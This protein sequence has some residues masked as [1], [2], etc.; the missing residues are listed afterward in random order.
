[1]ALNLGQLI[2]GGAAFARGQRETEQAERIARQ[3]QLQIEEQNRLNRLR[4]IQTQQAGQMGLPQAPSRFMDF[5]SIGGAPPGPLALAAPAAA[6]AVAPP[7]AAAPPAAPAAA[8]AA[9]PVV[10]KTPSERAYDRLKTDPAAIQAAGQGLTKDE[11]LQVY[12]VSLRRGDIDLASRLAPF[13]ITKHGVGQQELA[14]LQGQMSSIRR[15]TGEDRNIPAEIATGL[16]EIA[17]GLGFGETA[18]EARRARE[19]QRLAELRGAPAAPPAAAPPAAP[20]AAAPTTGARGIRNNNPGNIRPSDDKWQG[21]TGVDKAGGGKGYITFDT[22]ENGI[23]AMTKNLMTYQ[24]RGL[25]TVEKIINTWAPAADKND[26]EAYIRN[27]TNRLG[28]ARDSKLNL[29]NP[30]VMKALVTSIIQHENGAMPYTDQVLN[31]GIGAG[32]GTEPTMV[33]A[34]APPAAAPAAPEIKPALVSTAGVSTQPERTAERV[35]SY[36]AANPQ[37][38][39]PDRENL[40]QL[41][42]RQRERLANQYN[43]YVQSGMGPQAMELLGEVDKLDQ[44]YRAERLMLDGTEALAQLEYGNDPRAISAVLS[45][46]RGQPVNFEAVQDGRFRMTMRDQEGKMQE[47]GIYSREEVG[48]MVREYYD[49][50]YREARQAFISKVSEKRIESQLKTQE[51]LSEIQAQMIKDTAVEMVK[52]NIKQRELGTEVVATNLGDGKV[53]ISNKAGT[54]AFMIDTA[55]GQVQNMDGIEVPVAPTAQPI[56]GF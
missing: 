53:I 33:A 45:F 20:A 16:G 12:A 7:P 21:M 22:P 26:V 50:A 29:S 35:R 9:A 55:S 54:R 43:A 42:N 23:R 56:F 38:I 40:D 41:Y 46:Y 30:N 25:D 48:M 14:R 34:A 11:L 44:A 32:L 3:Q 24:G 28:V 37:N 5:G 51:K 39:G 49:K 27:V 19:A 4:Q 10:E 17:T 52:S 2:T 15:A 8:P 13:L 18:A 6:P 36:Y 47:R 1:M 31:A